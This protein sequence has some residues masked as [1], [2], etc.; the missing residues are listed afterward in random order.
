M[1][2]ELSVYEA[3]QQ[4][5]GFVKHFSNWLK[6]QIFPICSPGGSGTS[7]EPD[8]RLSDSE[9][10]DDGRDDERYGGI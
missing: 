7:K 1:I 6:M 5:V 3:A 2:Y 9:N 8:S 10:E 4:D